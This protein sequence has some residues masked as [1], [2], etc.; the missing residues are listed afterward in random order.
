MVPELAQYTQPDQ[1]ARVTDI[2]SVIGTR[3]LARREGI[4]AGASGGAVVSALLRSEQRIPEGGTVV[5][6]LHDDGQAYMNTVYNPEWVHKTLGLTEDEVEEA[7]HHFAES[8]TSTSA[9]SNTRDEHT[10]QDSRSEEQ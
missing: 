2:D 10:T 6:I 7:I 4:L 1:I 8:P 3:I 5:L 9:T